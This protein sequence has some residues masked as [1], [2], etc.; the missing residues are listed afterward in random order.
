MVSRTGLLARRLLIRAGLL[1]LLRLVLL[2]FRY[3]RRERKSALGLELLSGL[4][5]LL[6]PPSTGA[7]FGSDGTTLE[8][9]LLSFLGTGLLDFSP[10]APPIGE[11]VGADLGSFFTKA[12]KL[13]LPPE[14][15]LLELLASVFV[16]TLSAVF[17]TATSPSCTEPLSPTTDVGTQEAAT[18]DDS[19]LSNPL[20]TSG[21]TCPPAVPSEGVTMDSHTVSA[22]MGP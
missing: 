8:S 18:D 22:V 6:L 15:V 5:L 13:S 10:E 20:A 4:E 17:F 7:H 16:L 21:S 19:L 12:V 1:S 9:P 3:D 11:S 2:L 14:E